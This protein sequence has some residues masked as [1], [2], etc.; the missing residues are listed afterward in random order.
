MIAKDY[1]AIEPRMLS[2]KQAEEYTG[3]GRNTL[4]EFAGK[5]GARRKI[6]SPNDSAQKGRTQKDGREE[7]KENIAVRGLTDDLR[8]ITQRRG[9]LCINAGV[10]TAVMC[11]RTAD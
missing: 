3:M 1:K 10:I 2:Q 11:T 8:N 6:K 4:A 5:V 9:R 7:N